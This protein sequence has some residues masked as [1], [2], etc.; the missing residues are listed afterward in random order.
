M[1]PP[2]R[3]WLA[4]FGFVAATSCLASQPSRPASPIVTAASEWPQAHRQAMAEARQSRLGLA[5]RV[6]TDF[7]QRFPESPEAAEVSYWRAVYKLDPAN[8]SAM[9]DGM[10]LLEN[11]LATAERGLHRVEAMTMRRLATALESRSAALAAQSLAS[12]P[13][14]E[15]RAREEELARLRDD[16]A[17]A[18]AEL[19]RIK[20]RLARPKP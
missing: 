2:A 11:Y 14:S 15:D 1:M 7:A 13:K 16:L 18:N 5:D 3:A 17:K 4:A 8:P 12:V 9:R 6:L 20:R 10:V 19:S